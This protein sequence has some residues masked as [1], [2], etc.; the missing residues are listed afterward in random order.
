MRSLITLVLSGLAMVSLTAAQAQA[1]SSVI[2]R[3]HSIS[4]PYIGKHPFIILVA[5]LLLTHFA[6]CFGLDDELQNRWFDFGGD[7]IINTNRHIRLTSNRQ[8][9]LGHL[10]SR[11][12]STLLLPPKWVIGHILTF[13]IMILCSLLLLMISRL[14][15]NSAWMVLPVICMVM[16]LPV[17]IA[18]AAVMF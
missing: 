17:S 14:N 4:M 6:F 12:V 11:L 9:Q 7:T 3:T 10:W 18:P 8:S 13:M 16:V 5:R 2:L 15:L 1:P